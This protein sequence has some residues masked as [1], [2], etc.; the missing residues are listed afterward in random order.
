LEAA[1]RPGETTAASDAS[2]VGERHNHGMNLRGTFAVLVVRAALAD[3]GFWERTAD[4]G[5]PEYE[6]A[7]AEGRELVAKLGRFASEEA[8]LAFQRAIAASPRRAEGHLELG[9]VLFGLPGREEEAVDSLRRGRELGADDSD[10]RIAFL[11]GVLLT[12]LSDLEG[13]VREYRRA[14]RADSSPVTLSNAA[15]ALMALERLGEAIAL[16]RRAV[17]VS[18]GYVLAWWGLA[19]A[20]DRDEQVAAASKAARQAL[21]LDPT[22]NVLNEDGVFFVPEDDVY[23]Y[24]AVGDEA[25]GRTRAAIRNYRRFVAALPASPWVGRAKRHIEELAAGLK[26]EGRAPERHRRGRRR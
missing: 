3:G 8:A 22:M 6:R 5:R 23:Y 24:Q 11:L 12:K 4:P 1:G 9:K 25:A 19:V 2:T 14:A 26:A 21:G 17:A 7:M 18:P 13:A 15:E 20:L 16:Y 10:G